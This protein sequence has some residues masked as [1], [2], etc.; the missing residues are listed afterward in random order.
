MKEFKDGLS[1]GKVME[2]I[3]TKMEIYI[4]GNSKGVLPMA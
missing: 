4:Q 3:L 1:S 2:L